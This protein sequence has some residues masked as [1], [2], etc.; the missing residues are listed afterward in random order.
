MK[1]LQNNKL[2]IVYFILFLALTIGGIVVLKKTVQNL[3]E[4]DENIKGNK[5]LTYKK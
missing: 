5:L 1:P 2:K 4:K 3:I